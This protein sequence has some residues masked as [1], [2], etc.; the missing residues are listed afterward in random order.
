MFIF[1]SL[2]SNTFLQGDNDPIDVVE[3]GCKVAHR[4]QVLRV[5]ILGC[6]ALVDEGETDWKIIVIDYE[7][8]IA[9][10][11]NGNC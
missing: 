4:G 9:G 10:Q 5:K 7:D 1:E 2:A 11:V 8:P 3:I 6:L